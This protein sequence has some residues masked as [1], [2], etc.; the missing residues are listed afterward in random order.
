MTSIVVRQEAD[1]NLMVH[2]KELTSRL[3]RNT[4]SEVAHY[5]R[6]TRLKMDEFKFRSFC[7][8]RKMW[9]L[10]EQTT[11][12]RFFRKI[13]EKINESRKTIPKS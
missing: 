8:E 5:T 10:L 7:K 9:Y 3:K 12:V 2:L 6:K 13:Q 11:D 1:G 4:Q